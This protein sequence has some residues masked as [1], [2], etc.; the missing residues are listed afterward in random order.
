VA[1]LA[2][3]VSIATLFQLAPDAGAHAESPRTKGPACDPKTKFAGYEKITRGVVE[4]SAEW[5]VPANHGTAGTASTWIG[6]WGNHNF[7]QIGTDEIRPYEE[8]GFWSDTQLTDEAQQIEL[9]AAGDNVRATISYEG[10]KW[11][12]SLADLTTGKSTSISYNENANFT[13]AS[14]MQEDSSMDC[15]ITTYPSIDMRFRRVQLNGGVPQLTARTTTAYI[16]ESPNGRY[17]TAKPLH[18]DAFTIVPPTGR[19]ARYLHA[20]GPVNVAL[21]L[22]IGQVATRHSLSPLIAVTFA[23]A[24]LRAAEHF[25]KVLPR[26]RDGRALAR[27]TTVLVGAIKKALAHYQHSKQW[28]LAATLKAITKMRR[29]ADRVR[30]QVGLPRILTVTTLVGIA[31]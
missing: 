14:W 30:H 7:I 21:E 28:T 17:L 5:T 23:N 2:L 13:T 26:F 18:G 3:V 16:L 31:A 6:L 25:R 11:Q 15:S 19:A 12:L 27:N 24:A 10:T 22:W 1:G 4:I 29:N 9:I 20:S 8:E